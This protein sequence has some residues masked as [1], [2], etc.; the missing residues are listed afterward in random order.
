MHKY[1]TKPRNHEEGINVGH[2]QLRYQQ[3]KTTILCIYIQTPISK[4]YSSYKLKIYTNKNK[5][6]KY[7][8]EDSHQTTRKE[9]QIQNNDTTDTNNYPKCK[10]TK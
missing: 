8:T 10:W 1:A 9:K 3:L 4:L 7:N 5:Q 2:L 6:S